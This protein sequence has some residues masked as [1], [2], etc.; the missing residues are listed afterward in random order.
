M[1]SDL[2]IRFETLG[3]F[4]S[5]SIIFETNSHRQAYMY[6]CINAN[7]QNLIK[8]VRRSITIFLKRVYSL[9]KK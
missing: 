6:K 4:N 3:N 9:R 8:S 7:K 1:N 2:L 5:K